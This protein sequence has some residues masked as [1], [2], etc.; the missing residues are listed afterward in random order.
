MI[1]RMEIRFFLIKEVPSYV[2]VS[3]RSSNFKLYVEEDNVRFGLE[4]QIGACL[5]EA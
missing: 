4:F 1:E 5:E 2:L 3:Y